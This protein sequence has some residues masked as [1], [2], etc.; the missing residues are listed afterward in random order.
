MADSDF[1]SAAGSQMLCQLLRKIDGAV[2]ASGAAE[3]DHEIFKAA[4][5]IA[6]HA[7]I[8]K[9]EN[10]GQILVLAVLLIEIVDDRRVLACQHTE[11]FFAPRI[12]KAPRVEDISAAV[13]GFIGGNFAVE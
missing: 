12:G 5:L 1:H 8:R 9:R 7:G 4:A 13:A 6:A 10:V 3:G 2:L 11:L